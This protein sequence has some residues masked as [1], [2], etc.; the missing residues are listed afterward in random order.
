MNRVLLCLVYHSGHCFSTAAPIHQKICYNSC[1]DYTVA[2]VYIF[3]HRE[4]GS[5]L[6]DAL[7]IRRILKKGSREAADTLISKYYDELYRFALRQVET[8]EDALDLTQEIFITVLHALSGYDS[9]KASFRT[10]LY[11]IATNKTIDMRRKYKPVTL[12][13]DDIEPIQDDF[14]S[15]VADKALLSDIESYVC[16]LPA[17]LQRVFRLRIYGEHSFPDIAKILDMPEEKIKAQFYRL[18]KKLRKEFSPHE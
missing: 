4:G 11:K 8:K 17:E 3:R 16:T 12:S 9:K 7:L 10:W 6:D 14:V 18:S 5:H 13:F 15:E 1:N 2:D